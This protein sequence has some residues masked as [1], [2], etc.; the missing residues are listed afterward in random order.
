MFTG[1]LETNNIVYDYDSRPIFYSTD[2]NQPY[3]TMP[4]QD[5]Q[6]NF[7]INHTD[8]LLPNIVCYD[9]YGSGEIYVNLNFPYTDFDGSSFFIS[10]VSSVF[11]PIYKSITENPKIFLPTLESP[12]SYHNFDFSTLSDKDQYHPDSAALALLSHFKDSTSS[13]CFYFKLPTVFSIQ[14]MPTDLNISSAPTPVC[15]YYT[16]DDIVSSHYKFA[17]YPS[18]YMGSCSNSFLSSSDSLSP[19][20]FSCSSQKTCSF[21]VPLRKFISKVDVVSFNSSSSFSFSLYENTLFQNTDSSIRNF[22]IIN[23]Q[24]KDVVHNFSIPSSDSSGNLISKEQAETQVET[25]FQEFLL[26]Y[27]DSEI[28]QSPQEQ[29]PSTSFINTLLGS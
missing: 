18:T 14:P 8:H 12:S 19:C 29:K 13:P 27:N 11:A 20:R 2:H 1:Y 21:Y 6:A 3:F 23:E 9:F 5:L 15:E 16:H 10:G 26:T 22:D 24:T 17:N 25:I 28:S 7:Y 4:V